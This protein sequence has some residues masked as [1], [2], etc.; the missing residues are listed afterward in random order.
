MRIFLLLIGF[1]LSLLSCKKEPQLNDRIHDDLVEMGVAKDSIQ[2]MDTILGK[3][4]KKNTAFLDYY[5]HNYY[6][7][8]K[9]IQDEIKKL[10]G[11]QFVYDKDEEYFTLFTKIAT[12]K[13]DQYLKS[14]GM[15]GEEEH[16]ALE[17]YILR[18]KKKYGPTIDE[19]MRNLN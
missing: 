5:F 6:E 8:D 3:L 10:K 4:N 18:L 7:L 2:K 15:T 13:G 14:L 12:Q 19:R 9:E 11:E 17:L 16:F 1:S